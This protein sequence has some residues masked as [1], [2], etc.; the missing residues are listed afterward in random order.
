MVPLYIAM[1][2]TVWSGEAPREVP[3]GGEQTL[4]S[5][6]CIA[7]KVCIPNPQAEHMAPRVHDYDFQGEAWMC[8]IL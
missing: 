4:N 2:W 7:R 1:V 3:A 8:A 5:Y 6:Q